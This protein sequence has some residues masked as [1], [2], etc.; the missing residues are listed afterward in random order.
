[1]QNYIKNGKSKITVKD[2]NRPLPI[3]GNTCRFVNI[4]KYTENINI[5]VSIIAIVDMNSSLPPTMTERTTEY[6]FSTAYRTWVYSILENVS[7][8]CIIFMYSVII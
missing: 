6:T 2:F 5:V 3:T 7:C 4:S 8:A 1:M